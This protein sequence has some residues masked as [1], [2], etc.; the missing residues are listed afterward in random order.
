MLVSLCFRAGPSNSKSRD[1]TP[2]PPV[3]RK[4]G[5]YFVG[6]F[7]PPRPPR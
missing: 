2:R 5:A 4:V 3:A 6:S 1:L 7:I